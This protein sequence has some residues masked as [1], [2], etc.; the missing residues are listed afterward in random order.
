MGEVSRPRG[1]DWGLWGIVAAVLAG[2]G[3][4]LYGLG[5][6]AFWYDELVT[7][8]SL[9]EPSLAGF[10]AALKKLDPP[11]QP[12][13]YTAIYGWYQEIASSTF[14]LRLFPSLFGIGSIAVAGLAARRAFGSG[15]GLVTA[16][17]LALSFPHTY[18]SQEIRVYAFLLLLCAVSVYGFVRMAEDD[19]LVWWLL[20]VTA[21]GLMMITHYFAAFWVAA[22]LAALVVRRGPKGTVGWALAHAP[23]AA[24]VLYNVWQIDH[25]QLD[26]ATEWIGDP[27]VLGMAVRFIYIYGGAR[28]TVTFLRAGD[29]PILHLV[30]IALVVLAALGSRALW[31]SA[32]A[33][34]DRWERL[35]PYAAMAVLCL[36][37]PMI[38]GFFH[39]FVRPSFL[40][41]Y[42][43]Y[44]TIPLF[45]LI[46]GLAAAIPGVW[47]RRGA[48]ALFM[49]AL[50]V[51]QITALR[52]LRTPYDAIAAAL[53]EAADFRRIDVFVPMWIDRFALEY[54]APAPLFRVHVIEDADYLVG[55][56]V[57]SV[58]Q[59]RRAWVVGYESPPAHAGEIA[60]VIAG[61]RA[62][63]S[64]RSFPGMRRIDLYEV[65]DPFAGF[66]QTAEPKPES[67][68]PK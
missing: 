45:V 49:A 15:A 33:Q 43:F 26:S 22:M 67:S 60:E 34:Q 4:R 11:M 44:V 52:P 36:A 59:G 64:R 28:L 27:S 9:P 68:P 37:P 41:R 42:T 56:A 1:L 23:W 51:A 65:K 2:A 38:L 8:S 61:E 25:A 21:N 66:N 7:V 55:A 39:E 5:A 35:R 62:A 13:F 10:L 19:G 29:M 54:Y 48:V 20:T 53:L 12:L 57:D 50:C 24:M 18:Y 31:R 3:L 63:A 32:T 30:P 17:G 58:R 46:G 6:E 14:G 40:P 16:W 47:R